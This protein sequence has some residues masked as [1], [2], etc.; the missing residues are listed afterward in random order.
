MIATGATRSA[1]IV[2]IT[3]TN[4]AA[5]FWL[6]LLLLLQI[7]LRVLL[8]L[9]AQLWRQVL[10]VEVLVLQTGI[11]IEA[12]LLANNRG[13]EGVARLNLHIG[14]QTE[15]TYSRL[16]AELPR[17]LLLLLLM[18]LL[19]LLEHRIADVVGQQ[20]LLLLLLLKW[21]VIVMGQ[22]L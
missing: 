2:C 15:V 20:Q 10:P 22:G 1:L 13:G 3:W 16:L 12:R 8:Q 19:L 14:I 21:L 11:G 4:V 6:L 9:V 18:L 7:L 5:G 17:P